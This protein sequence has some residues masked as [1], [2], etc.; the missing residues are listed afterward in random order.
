MTNEEMKARFDKLLNEVK[1]TTQKAAK[2]KE[3]VLE[4]KNE[5]EVFIEKSK[6]QT[7]NNINS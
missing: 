2:T 6:N 4:L 1:Q 7:T 3:G 5:I